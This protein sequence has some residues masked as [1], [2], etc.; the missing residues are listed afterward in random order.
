MDNERFKKIDD[1][2]IDLARVVAISDVTLNEG[3]LKFSIYFDNRLL[4]FYEGIERQTC[5]VAAGG[6]RTRMGLAYPCD[7]NNVYQVLSSIPDG[8]KLKQQVELQKDVD[9]LIEQWKEV[10]CRNEKDE[11]FVSIV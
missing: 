3:K 2:T 5:A 11:S 7:D 10:C 1:I 8:V 4:K 6:N 9:E